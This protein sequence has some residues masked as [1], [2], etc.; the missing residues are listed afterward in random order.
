MKIYDFE[1]RTP[2]W[3]A[4]RL[5]MP[6]ASNFD[7][8]VTIDGK[9]S[10]QRTKYLYQVAGEFLSGSS[11]ESYQSYA[12]LRGCELEQEAINL[13]ELIKGVSVKKVGFV[14]NNPDFEFG[15]SPD[16]L[17]NNDGMIQIK[18]PNMATHVGYIVENKF[19][20]DYF[21]Q[22]QGE[23]LV[24]DRKWSDFISYY[25]GLKPLIVRFKRDKEFINKLKSELEI[26][27]IELKETIKKIGA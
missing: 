18:C 27:C 12:M 20:M 6:T 1:Q 2:E 26:F 23:L 11:E 13:Y 21:Q 22:I 24:T 14:V 17:I 7:K 5:G 8:I 25:P 9:P 19:P 16:G 4:I 3:Y 10:K 15:C